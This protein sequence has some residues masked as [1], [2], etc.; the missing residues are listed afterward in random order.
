[1]SKQ[2]HGRT[3]PPV[4]VPVCSLPAQGKIESRWARFKCQHFM[5]S[6]FLIIPQYFQICV[7]LPQFKSLGCRLVFTRL[8]VDVSCH[9]A[10]GN[11]ASVD[12]C[13]PDFMW[14]FLVTVQQVTELVSIGVYK[15]LCGC[16]LS[17][18]NR[19]LSYCRLVCTRLYVDVSCHCA[20]G[21]WASVDWCVQDFMWMFLVTV[22]QVTELVSIG[23]YKTLCGCFLSL[24][25]R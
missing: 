16:F 19:W 4:R 11:W 9:C 15:T 21:N 25:N 8:Y 5:F 1:M 6:R 20:T 7:L 13:V 17:L 12:W 3:L 23:V 18:C 22:Q 24:C 10:T 2:G 14:M